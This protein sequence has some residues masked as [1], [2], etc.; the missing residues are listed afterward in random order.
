MCQMF[1][2]ILLLSDLNCYT[3]L[4]GDVW[5]VIFVLREVKFFAALDS[6]ERRNIL[7]IRSA[8]MSV[9]RF[10]VEP[11]QKKFK[12]GKMKTESGHHGYAENPIH[13]RK[14]ILYR[15]YIIFL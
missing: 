6:C 9:L 14:F 15:K 2:T 5:N 13:S 10:S 7:K 8:Y 1:F 4:T 3:C 11:K 12:N